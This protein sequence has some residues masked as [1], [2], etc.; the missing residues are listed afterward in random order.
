MPDGSGHIPI[1]W[2]QR[3]YIRLAFQVQVMHDFVLCGPFSY[4]DD[5]TNSTLTTRYKFRFKWG[6]NIIPEQIIKNPYQR[7]QSLTSY[8]D[9]QRRDLQV[10]DP[11]TMG[12]IYTFHT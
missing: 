6:G 5:L 10:I 2:Q 3:W 9:R 4:K 8:P 7:K 12:P 11:S 1:Y